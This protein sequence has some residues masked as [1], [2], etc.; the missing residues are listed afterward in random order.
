MTHMVKGVAHHHFDRGAQRIRSK[1]LATPG[2]FA[3]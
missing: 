1:L 3:G 2:A